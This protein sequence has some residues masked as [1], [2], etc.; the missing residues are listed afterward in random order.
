MDNPAIGCAVV[1]IQRLKLSPASARRP[2]V[3][4]THVLPRLAL[5]MVP[6]LT[7]P[8]AFRP[9]DAAS[10][11][12]PGVYALEEWHTDT[13]VL[14]VPAIYG[15][16]I[17]VD[18]T[19]TTVLRAHGTAEKDTTMV[20]LG[21]YELDATHFAYVYDNASAFTESPSGVTASHQ[22][23]WEGMRS[24]SMQANRDTV[25][26]Q[27]ASAQKFVFTRRGVAYFGKPGAVLRIWRRCVAAQ[28]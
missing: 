18:G 1:S 22:L 4:V 19:I 2:P 12:V 15:R 23:P 11:L 24:F 25:T 20:N 17:L 7:T 28:C 8:T 13:A 14:K 16:L 6:F 3:R 5:G 10:A 9:V 21:H 27:S 26:L